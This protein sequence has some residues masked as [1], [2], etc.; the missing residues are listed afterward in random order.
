[1]LPGW[2]GLMAGISTVGRWEIPG[3]ADPGPLFP[4]KTRAETFPGKHLSTAAASS[5]V[6]AFRAQFL[7]AQFLA[8]RTLY[9]LNVSAEE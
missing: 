7:A 1:M 9:T 5:A 6:C 2:P 3:P 8:A 4:S